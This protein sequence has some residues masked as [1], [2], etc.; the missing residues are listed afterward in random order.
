MSRRAVVAL[1][2]CGGLAAC[3][4]EPPRLVER[5][6][7]SEVGSYLDTACSTSV[8]LGLSQQIAEEVGCLVPGQ[9]VSFTAQAN[10]VF[11]G[12]AVLPYLSELG[13]GDLL[14]AAAAQ[15]ATTL[16]INSAYR[17]VAQQYLLHG[18][19]QRGRC[20]ISA[21]ATPGNSNHESGR[22]IDVG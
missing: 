10:V 18:W 7:G 5:R 13:R 14:A 11:A 8:V 2:L 19:W 6:Q 20:N 3:V 4:D 16:S 22:A 15:P 12:S 9:L 1:S 21:A 17:T